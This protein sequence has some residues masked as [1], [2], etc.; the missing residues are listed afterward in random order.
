[1]HE[2]LY[3]DLILSV[4]CTFGHNTG[5]VKKKCSSN[6]TQI[7]DCGHPQNLASA[8][9]SASHQPAMKRPVMRV[10]HDIVIPRVAAYWSVLADY[11]EYEL[12]YKQLIQ[13]KCNS[14][15]LECCVMLLEDWLSSKRGISPKS[16]GVLIKILKDIKLLTS[17]AEKIEEDLISAGVEIA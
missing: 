6:S 1:M 2:C 3:R 13:K 15:P 11:L 5:S 8:S 10:L 17:A 14:D 9:L 7:N 16:W 4:V 12:E